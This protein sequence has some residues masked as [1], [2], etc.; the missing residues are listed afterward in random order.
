MPNLLLAGMRGSFLVWTLPFD[1][2]RKVEP[3]VPQ[4]EVPPGVVHKVTE[5]HKS[6]QGTKV[7]THGERFVYAIITK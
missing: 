1:Q 6:H 7:M 3:T 5:P 4:T 2:T